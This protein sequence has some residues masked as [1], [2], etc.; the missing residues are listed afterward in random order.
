MAKQMTKIAMIMILAI[1]LMASA[2]TAQNKDDGFAPVGI[3]TGVET[4]QGTFES[5]SAMRYGNTY[6]LNSSGE[7]ES[8]HLTVSLNYLLSGTPPLQGFSVI[9]GNWSLVVIRDN[10]YAGTLYGEV[11]GG[12]ITFIENANGETTSKR[13]Q[14]NLQGKGGLGIFAGKNS[15]NIVGVYDAITDLLR[16]QRCEHLLSD[17]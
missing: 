10:Q 5:M 14:V 6:V 2:A 16:Q 17:N 7:W 8:H 9:S 15:E 3:Y 12:A 4:A 13:I 1:G 11:T